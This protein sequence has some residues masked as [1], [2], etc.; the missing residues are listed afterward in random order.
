M[1]H[2]CA[3]DLDPA[4]TLAK[5]ATL[6]AA[7]KAGNV[8]LCAGLGEGEV[9]GTEAAAGILAKLCLCKGL[10][11]A[12]EVAHGNALVNHKTF[13]LVEQ[14]RVGSIHRVGAVYA[15]GGDDA[16]RRLLYLHGSRLYG[17]GLRA[18]QD[19]IRDVEGIL[20]VSCGVIFRNIELLEV[21]EVV[22]YLG[23]F[24]NREAHTDKDLFHISLYAGQGVYV[25]YASGLAGHGNVQLFSLELLLKRRC[26]KC[27]CLLCNGCLD[28]LAHLVCQLTDNGSFLGT[29]LAH[30]AQNGGQLTLFA[31]VLNSDLLKI[32][33]CSNL[34]KRCLANLIQHF[35]HGCFL[36]LYLHIIFIK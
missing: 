33:A 29:Q 20:R 21:V 17:R 12:L 32:F 31:K 3:Q 14:G 6:A 25:T 15:A 28:L 2:T 7:S 8:N 30:T 5:S 16:D 10:Q 11:H 23:A 19:V 4:L 27:L 35:F 1:H 34:F 13:H 18:Q 9:V 22:F 26:L 24:R 36:P